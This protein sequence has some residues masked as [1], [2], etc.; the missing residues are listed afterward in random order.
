MNNEVKVFFFFLNKFKF[1]GFI[2]I[3]LPVYNDSR[4]GNVELSSAKTKLEIRSESGDFF[5]YV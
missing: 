3:L 4:L 2:M 5:K 1:I